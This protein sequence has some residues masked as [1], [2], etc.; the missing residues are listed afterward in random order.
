VTHHDIAAAAQRLDRKI[1]DH[2]TVDV[3]AAVDFGGVETMG[4]ED[5]ARM[6]EMSEP[7]SKIRRRALMM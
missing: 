1:V 2:T 6:A 7:D 5:E 4:I 3:P